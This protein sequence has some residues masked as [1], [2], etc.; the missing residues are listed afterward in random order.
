MTVELGRTWC[1]RHGHPRFARLF[2]Q[3]RRS[4]NASSGCS[5]AEAGATTS[6]ATAQSRFAWRGMRGQEA[7]FDDEG[8]GRLA[9]DGRG[10]AG[11]KSPLASIFVFQISTASCVEHFVF[12]GRGKRGTDWNCVSTRASAKERAQTGQL[13]SLQKKVF[14]GKNEV[15]TNLRLP[16]GCHT[17]LLIPAWLLVFVSRWNYIT[18]MVNVYLFISRIS[19]QLATHLF[20]IPV[21][22]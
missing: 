14:L 11:L 19:R 18:I 8:G 21:L 7:G 5:C 4:S 3:Q 6:H 16:E 13:H 15:F 9:V 22:N 2:R 12:L 10:R 17:R 1:V 20:Y